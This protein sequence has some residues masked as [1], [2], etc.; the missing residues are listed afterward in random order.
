MALTLTPSRMPSFDRP[1]VKFEAAALTEPPIR[2]S[3]STVR[4]APPMMFTTWPCAV[5]RLGR[6][7]E[8]ALRALAR[9]G[10]RDRPADAPAAARNN[11]DLA[12][13]LSRHPASSVFV[14]SCSASMAAK[15][16]GTRRP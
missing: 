5:L 9:E 15:G 10:G 13:E 11:D 6:R 14:W 8:H 4:P 1:L 7:G 2:N 16:E 3:G 12:V